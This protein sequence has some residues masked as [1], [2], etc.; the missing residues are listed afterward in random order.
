MLPALPVTDTLKRVATAPSPAR[1][2]RD[3]LHRAQTPQGF[4]YAAIL[5]AHERHA[6]SALT[7]DVALAEAAGLPVAVVAGD[8]SNLK[9]TTQDDLARAARLLGGGL[10]QRTGLGFDVHR[11]AAG[12]RP[13][14]ARRAAA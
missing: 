8:E 3:G 10:V 2:T 5:A 14:A 9:I 13:R 7:D 1:S 12:R 6:G 4:R 11:L